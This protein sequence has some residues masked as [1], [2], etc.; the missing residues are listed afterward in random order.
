MAD[1]LLV[2]LLKV[3]GCRIGGGALTPYALHQSW[4]GPPAEQ[5]SWCAEVQVGG[6]LQCPSGALIL[7]A[8][9]QTSQLLLFLLGAVAG[10]LRLHCLLLLTHS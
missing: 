8:A 3:T 9:V 2:P 10:A 4:A 7:R 1:G 5:R 6:G